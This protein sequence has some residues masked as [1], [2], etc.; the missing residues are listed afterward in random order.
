M[1]SGFELPP[2]QKSPARAP[3]ILDHQKSQAAER[4]A[5]PEDECDQIRL[6]ESVLGVAR[7]DRA[8]NPDDYADQPDA[9]RY[10]LDSP[11]ILRGSV[12]IVRQ[13]PCPPEGG[14]GAPDFS[15]ALSAASNFCLSSALNSPAFAFWLTCSARM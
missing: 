3:Q 5:G 8:D 2:D 4:D 6:K 11:E 7:N 15:P 12:I 13:L 1:R 14:V 10:V 9:H